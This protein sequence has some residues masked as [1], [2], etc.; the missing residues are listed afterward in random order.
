MEKI[1]FEKEICGTYLKKIA[2][3]VD[4]V[5]MQADI[6]NVQEL[7]HKESMDRLSA[8]VER[9]K[10]DMGDTVGMSKELDRCRETIGSLKDDISKKDGQIGRLSKRKKE[11]M[12]L[13]FRSCA[14]SV[15][16]EK[17]F[18]KVVS[19]FTTAYYYPPKKKK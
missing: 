1:S 5:N 19:K 7:K 11:R 9:F 6:I 18:G 14:K 8:E 10:K 4:K 12:Y 16:D 15:L 17:E 13:L 3:L 2:E